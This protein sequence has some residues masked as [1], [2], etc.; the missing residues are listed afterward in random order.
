MKK[1]L[2]VLFTLLSTFLTF[3]EGWPG[4][5]ETLTFTYSIDGTADP[6]QYKMKVVITNTGAEDLGS[7][8]D[9]FESLTA[10]VTL[11]GNPSCYPSLEAGA[12][13]EIEFDVDLTDASTESFELSFK[14]KDGLD[15]Q[16]YCLE[17]NRFWLGSALSV[18]EID[19]SDMSYT[20]TYFD[21]MG[22]KVEVLNDEGFFIEK[23]TYEDGYVM[24][25]KLY[26]SAE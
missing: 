14:A 16:L 3:A 6:L 18:E 5:C 2:L 15:D 10:G 20:S 11:S 4:V 12:T 21:L 8:C 24:V 1:S 13:K 7:Y 22:R 9:V 25:E 17:V 19:R 23:R 26:L